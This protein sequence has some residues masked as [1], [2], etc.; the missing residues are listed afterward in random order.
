M[1]LFP[2]LFIGAFVLA[3]TSRKQHPRESR[4]ASLAMPSGMPL[5]AL[6][7]PAPPSPLMVLSEYARTAVAPPPIVIMCAI[8]EAES[9]GREDVADEII[10][11]FIAPV[12]Y[13]HAAMQQMA[14]A[15]PMP[16]PYPMP[17][18]R[19]ARTPANYE[20]GGYA[21]GNQPVQPAAL[22]Q[23]R[24]QLA[25]EPPR[26]SD[27]QIRAMIRADPESFMSMLTQEVMKR[28]PMPIIEVPAVEQT[29]PAMAMPV[30]EIGDLPSVGVLD[31]DVPTLPSAP[32]SPI[33]GIA[34]EPWRQFVVCLSREDPAF[35][36]TR[37][38]GQFRQRRERLVELKIDPRSL[39]GDSDAQRRALD[40]D[41][42]DALRHAV[43]GGLIAEHLGK[44]VT[45]PG[46]E[47]PIQVTLSGLL[48]VIQCAGL[49]NGTSWLEKPR[50]RKNFPNTTQAFTR[51]NGVF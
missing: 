7:A 24:E 38:V 27:A 23:P 46:I 25:L 13:Q 37:H 35:T 48:G 20:R 8:A 4:L 18:A 30:P 22:P 16:M 11:A 12:V 31:I 3:A 1:W 47:E 5:P 45:L 42:V 32:G 49:E 21:R 33:E 28:E 2:L 34:D 19:A 15:Q 9:M 44:P 51:T 39:L 26:A 40:I 41:M 6:F 17:E 14:M 36:S 43:D 29:R 10:K 50:D